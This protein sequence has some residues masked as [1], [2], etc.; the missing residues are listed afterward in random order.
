MF[1]KSLAAITAA[2]AFALMATSANADTIT[3]YTSQSSYLTAATGGSAPA[4][5]VQDQVNWASIDA[6]LH[7]T[8]DGGTLA[9]GSTATTG[10]GEVVGISNNTGVAAT[11]FTSYVQG[12][13]TW[14]GQFATGTT[15]LYNG[16]SETTTLSFATA[17]SALGVDL[18]VQNTGAYTIQMKVYS[19]VGVGCS[20]TT[21]TLCTLLGTVSNTTG[22]S[23][24]IATANPGTVAFL[25]VTDTTGANISYVVLNSTNNSGGFAIDT[26]IIYHNPIN[27]TTGGGGSSPTPEPSTLAL[28]GVGLAGLGLLRRRRL[29]G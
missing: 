28:L 13:I 21:V 26:S 8:P 11:P 4:N 19:N 27:V 22:N 6:Q 18:Q 29:N 5:Q 1:N 23:T 2:G 9:Y 12:G 14:R 20:A 25:G 3:G 24:G 17:L 10:G 7:V 16:S 15:V